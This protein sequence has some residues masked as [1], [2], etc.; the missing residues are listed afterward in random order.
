MQL[1]IGTYTYGWAF[2]AAV[3]MPFD[4]LSLVEL[5]GSLD[6]SLVQIGD[7][8]PLHTFSGVRLRTF[9]NILLEKNIRLEV[10]ARGLSEANLRQY[11]AI[12]RELDAGL[13]RF[14]TDD[15]LYRPSVE[16]ITQIIRTHLH[17]LQE[18]NITLA[19]ENHDR[20]GSSELAGIIEAV[21]SP[22]A[23]I[24]LDTVNS[25]G[26]GEGIDTVI[27]RLGPHTVNL[28]IK[29]FG[30]QR[31]EHKQGYI[32]DGRIAGEGMLDIPSLL[33]R[34]NAYQR[35]GTCILEQWVPPENDRTGTIAKERYWAQKSMAY[36]RKLET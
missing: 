20:L 11:I 3:D 5:A 17:L 29:D 7:N 35:C 21:N 34:I 25:M 30:I 15:Q 27:D 32:I 8:L 16:D 23:G 18:Y 19:L 4:E 26:A 2:G 14:V 12:C 13:L 33:H 28:H 10:G 24:C 9:K 1:G 6:V 22:Y 31:L 36:L